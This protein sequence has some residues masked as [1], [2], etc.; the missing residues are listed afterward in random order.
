M[1]MVSSCLDRFYTETFTKSK[2]QFTWLKY[3]ATPKK[4]LSCCS[5]ILKCLTSTSKRY[6]RI[7]WPQ[8]LWQTVETSLR[9]L[10]LTFTSSLV[11]FK[12]R[13]STEKAPCPHSVVTGQW[14]PASS[15]W[16]AILKALL[17]KSM[18]RWPASL[19][20]SGTTPTATRLTM[21]PAWEERSL[22]TFRRSS[23]PPIR[24]S[25]LWMTTPTL[26]RNRPC[27]TCH[28]MN[29]AL[30][31]VS[32]RR[33]V[34]RTSTEDQPVKAPPTKKHLTPRDSW[35][36]PEMGSSE[37]QTCRHS[38]FLH[39]AR[40]TK[41]KMR[42][43]LTEPKLS[44]LPHRVTAGRLPRSTNLAVSPPALPQMEWAR[45]SPRF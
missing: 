33:V 6:L 16:W 21:S 7:K 27:L 22:L 1:R 17:I 9:T 41:N 2:I 24:C 15:A 12:S 35:A 20:P 18:A 14:A 37:R 26:Y 10:L 38:C 23:T 31:G 32:W 36:S 39:N 42:S 13:A 11:N 19:V 5:Q 8:D 4:S 43:K 40:Q 34:R 45:L 29:A 25:Q 28:L 30:A 44:R 3:P